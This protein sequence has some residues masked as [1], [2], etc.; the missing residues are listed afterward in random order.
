M[1]A[2]EKDHR[3]YEPPRRAADHW[4][5]CWNTDNLR[6]YAHNPIPMEVALGTI[7]TVLLALGGHAICFVAYEDAQRD[8]R[9]ARQL[10]DNGC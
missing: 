6:D 1:P 4:S 8:K 9:K 5:D 2:D 7:V 10:H 3:L